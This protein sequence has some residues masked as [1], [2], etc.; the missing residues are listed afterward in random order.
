[1]K[2]GDSYKEGYRI[3]PEGGKAHVTFEDLWVAFWKCCEYCGTR[4]ALRVVTEQMSK[5]AVD[6]VYK[7]LKDEIVG[8]WPFDQEQNEPPATL[9]PAYRLISTA[10]AM[11]EIS[12]VEK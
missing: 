3:P 9:G 1:M 11:L 8:S 7:E 5:N 6:E 4:A 10:K 12:G 2:Q